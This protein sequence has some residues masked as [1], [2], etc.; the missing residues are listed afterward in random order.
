MTLMTVWTFNFCHGHSWLIHANLHG[1]IFSTCDPSSEIN[2]DMIRPKRGC[3]TTS[4]CQYYTVGFQHP[5]FKQLVLGKWF[6]WSHFVH[7]LAYT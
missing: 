1:C 5:A 3:T 7:K 4:R 2:Q 6:D